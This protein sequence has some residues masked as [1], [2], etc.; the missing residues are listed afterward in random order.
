MN[1]TLFFVS[2]GL[3]ITVLLQGVQLVLTKRQLR[4]AEKLIKTYRQLDEAQ[5]RFINAL[6]AR[7]SQARYL[8][9]RHNG[10]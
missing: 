7:L 3:S 5:G 10:A 1:T 4:S 6:A 2:I 8:G 9:G